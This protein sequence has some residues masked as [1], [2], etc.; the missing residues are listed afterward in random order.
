MQSLG[1]GPDR[2]GE[3]VAAVLSEG[4]AVSVE[5][6]LRAALSYLGREQRA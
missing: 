3:A 2:A 5:G 1:V 6:L 4:P